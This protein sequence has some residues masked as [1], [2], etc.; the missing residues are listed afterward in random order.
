MPKLIRLIIVVSSFF[1][2]FMHL[3]GSPSISAGVV[4]LSGILVLSVE[5]LSYA[6][7]E[8]SIRMAKLECPEITVIAPTE[9]GAARL[10]NALRPGRVVPLDTSDVDDLEMK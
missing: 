4:L 5:Y 6:L 2:L 1:F 9:D 10:R 7:R 8:L 3:R